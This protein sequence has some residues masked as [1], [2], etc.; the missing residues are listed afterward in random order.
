MDLSENIMVTKEQRLDAMKHSLYLVKQ[1]LREY[2]SAIKDME[3]IIEDIE[4]YLVENNV[5]PEDF[6]K[7]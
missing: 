3:V 6:D 4:K 2:K 5:K 7:F 1:K